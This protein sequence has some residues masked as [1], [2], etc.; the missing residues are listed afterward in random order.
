VH[1]GRIVVTVT[2]SGRESEARSILSRFG[3]YDRSSAGS[4][5]TSPLHTGHSNAAMSNGSH[6]SQTTSHVTSGNT[7]RAVE[8]KLHVQKT[9]V[10]TGQVNVHKEV[11]TEHKTVEVPITR[12]EI[13]I[14]RRTPIG[15]TGNAADSGHQE[16]RIPVKEEEITIQKTPVVT[17][18]VSVSKRQVKG[19]ERVSADLRK[20][21]IKVE[22]D[23]DVNVRD[24]R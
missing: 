18:E 2:G 8:E 21:E 24:R 1:A 10:T 15:Q 3:G 17:E 20:E 19:T 14:E 6:S 5:T 12:E 23:G 16:I 9:P 7:V 13:V 4:A 22:K 11:H